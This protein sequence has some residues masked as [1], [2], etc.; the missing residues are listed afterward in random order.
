MPKHAQTC[1]TCPN[2]PKHAQHAQTKCPH[3]QLEYG[4]RSPYVVQAAGSGGIY[5]LLDPST[6]LARY[7]LNLRANVGLECSCHYVQEYTMPC[8]HAGVIFHHKK[9]LSTNRRRTEQVCK[10]YWPK[11]AQ[12]D[13]WARAYE[14][15]IIRRP[16]IH[17]GAFRGRE[18]DVIL[19]PLPPVKKRGR[20]KRSRRR[21][22]ISPRKLARTLTA[23][24]TRPDMGVGF[25]RN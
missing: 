24:V 13:N 18:A 19:P 14:N 2:M 22:R 25:M 11:W 5:Y 21:Q 6:R 3:V 1:P 9:F 20:P 4:K 7:E 12:Y 17:Q 8:R 15:Q 23:P 10:K 16:P